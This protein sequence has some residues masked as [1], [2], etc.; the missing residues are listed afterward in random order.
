MKIGWRTIVCQQFGAAMNMLENALRACPEH[1]WRD[2]IRDD[3]T[4][5]P[6]YTEFWFIAY[7]ALRY[8]WTDLYLS[9]ARREDFAPL[10]QK[11]GS[12]PDW[13]ARADHKTAWRLL[14]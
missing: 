2:R 6:E 9:G 7:H 3:P 13:V 1:L 4:D 10:W 11:I 5:A 12:A 8:A 14:C